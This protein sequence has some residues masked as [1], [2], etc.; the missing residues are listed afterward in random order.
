MAGIATGAIV[1]IGWLV[2][3][4]SVGVYEII[5]GFVAGLIAAVVVSLLSKAPDQDVQD[6]FDRASKPET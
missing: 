4:K 1:D 6:L 5:P 3:M 2:L